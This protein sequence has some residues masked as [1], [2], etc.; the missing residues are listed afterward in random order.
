MRQYIIWLSIIGGAAIL[1]FAG[2]STG[3]EKGK[4]FGESNT[5]RAAF[6][7]IFE[8]LSTV[9]PMVKEERSEQFARLEKLAEGGVSE[10]EA[11]KGMTNILKGLGD[12]SA[13]PPAGSALSDSELVQKH[14]EI[15]MRAIQ[16]NELLASFAQKFPGGPSFISYIAGESPIWNSKAPLFNRYV[17]TIQI[18]ARIDRSNRRLSLVGDP[19]IF[20]NEIESIHVLSDGRRRISY[21]KNWRL[22]TDESRKLL[23]TSASL[24]NLGIALVE[25]SPV[26]GF[27]DV[28]HY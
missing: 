15:V 20:L 2:L 3:F 9:K 17:I 21:G 22:N 14:D 12:I 5:G 26:S 27:G 28:L 16:E 19:E 1:F 7:T 4:T 18:P 10:L 8:L 6:L 11:T 25:D 13:N 23:H 24:E